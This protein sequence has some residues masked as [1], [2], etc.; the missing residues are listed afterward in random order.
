MEKARIG[1]ALMAAGE[2]SRHHLLYQRG[3]M[4]RIFRRFASVYNQE[5]GKKIP[6]FVRI[7]QKIG[8]NIL[9]DLEFVA[10]FGSLPSL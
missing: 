6:Q 10:S 8:P 9:I 1:L 2:E 4:S 7:L 3:E 5:T